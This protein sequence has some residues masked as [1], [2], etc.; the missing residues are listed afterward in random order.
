MLISIKSGDKLSE[1]LKAVIPRI[2]SKE[3]QLLYSAFGRETNG[4]KKLNFSGTQSYKY[5]LGIQYC[6]YFVFHFFN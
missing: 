1:S 6:S 2:I 5:L 4:S 3:V